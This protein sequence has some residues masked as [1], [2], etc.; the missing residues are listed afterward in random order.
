MTRTYTVSIEING[1]QVEASVE[2]RR[3][4]VDF[5]REDLGLTGTHASCEHGVCGS[6]TVLLDGVAVR[7]CLALTA[8]MNGRRI[9]TIEGVTP[10]AGLNPVQQAFWDMHGLQCGFC[11]PGFVMTLH[12]LLLERPNAHDEELREALNGVLCRCTGYQNIWR[13]ALR[14]RELAGVAASNTHTEERV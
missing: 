1:Q 11:T 3:L 9:T 5:L 2:G 12:A 4:L 6:C 14:A 8:Q 13:A 10:P 7:S